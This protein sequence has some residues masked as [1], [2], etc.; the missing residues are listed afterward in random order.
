MHRIFDYK[1]LQ[2]RS[3]CRPSL[4][5]TTHSADLES[6]GSLVL[7]DTCG[8]IFLRNGANV[9]HIRSAVTTQRI[10]SLIGVVQ[11][12]KLVVGSKRLGVG[13]QLLKSI[14]RQLV[15]QSIIGFVLP[16]VV[17]ENL[18]MRRLDN[19]I[20]KVIRKFTYGTCYPRNGRD[21]AHCLPSQCCA[22]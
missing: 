6:S 12:N 14:E 13:V 1:I 15:E 11:V 7:E 20:E 2:V 10:L 21:R 9:L 18:C 19:R 17:E 4:L 5:L 16:R 22:R 3:I 8:I